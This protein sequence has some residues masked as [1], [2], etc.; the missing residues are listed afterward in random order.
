MW[1][2]W[3]SFIIVTVWVALLGNI[4]ICISPFYIFVIRAMIKKKEMIRSYSPVVQLLTRFSFTEYLLTEVIILRTDCYF[5]SSHIIILK[6]HFFS[7]SAIFEYSPH[8]F[9]P[10]MKRF[11]TPLT[12]EWALHHQLGSDK[13]MI[14]KVWFTPLK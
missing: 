11:S 9:M 7:L 14:I 3:H 12:S 6:Q 4:W 13:T 5:Y 8:F 1:L 10:V 2:D